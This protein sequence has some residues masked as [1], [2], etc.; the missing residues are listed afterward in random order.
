MK[1]LHLFSIVSL[2]LAALASPTSA[3]QTGP[4]ANSARYGYGVVDVTYIFKHYQRFTT[5]MENMKKEMESADGQIKTER[6]AI[7]EKERAREQYNPGAPEFKQIDEEIARLKAEFQLKAGKI[8]RDF[9]ER[10]A[11]VY[12]QTYQEVSN[13]VQYYAQQH[14]I[15]MVLRFNGDAIDPNNREDILRAINKP[16]VFQN[17]VDITPDVLALLNR[18]GTPGG[19]LPAASAGAATKY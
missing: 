8:R 16:V 6:D 15:G 12:Y 17:N 3:Q 19:T 1:A 13:A 9:L 10:E 11:Q 5:S 14:N 2:G 4:S 18:G 7:V